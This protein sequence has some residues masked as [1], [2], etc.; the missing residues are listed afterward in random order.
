MEQEF[1]EDPQTADFTQIAKDIESASIIISSCRRSGKTHLT[2]EIM[3]H[4]GKVY[5]VDLCLLFSNTASYNPDFEYVSE[6]YKYDGLDEA[7]LKK[8][9]NQQKETMKLHR[10]MTKKNKSYNKQ[11]PKPAIIFDDV[12]HEKNLFYSDVIGELFIMARHIKVM[13]VFLTQ[14]LNALSPKMRN[15]ADVIISFRDPNWNNRRTL[16]DQFMTLSSMNRKLVQQYMDK[17]LGEAYRCIVVC[18][19]KGATGKHTV[20]LHLHIQSTKKWTKV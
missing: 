15:N 11:P 5:K 17:C 1:I 3:Y 10:A 8:F 6:F 13:V 7:L 19:Y 16:Q 14:H 20:R 12:A 4:M 2:R 9:V 18:V